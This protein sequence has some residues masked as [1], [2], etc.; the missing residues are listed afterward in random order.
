MLLFIHQTATRGIS[1]VCVDGVFVSVHA[2]FVVFVFCLVCVR[3]RVW[4]GGSAGR[5]Q[6]IWTQRPPTREPFP[7]TALSSADAATLRHY[8]RVGAAGNTHPG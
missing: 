4:S 3:V 8:G 7:P 1:G 5:C 6:N 2:E